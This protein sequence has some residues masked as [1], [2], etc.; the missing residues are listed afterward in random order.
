MEN[1]KPDIKYLQ[2]ALDIVRECESLEEAERR[3]KELVDQKE[4]ELSK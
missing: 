4:K 2:K 3:L 1:N